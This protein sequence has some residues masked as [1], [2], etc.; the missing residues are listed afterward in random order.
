LVDA[1]FPD[2]I[3]RRKPAV[4]K[5]LNKNLARDISERKRSE[6]ALQKSREERFAEINLCEKQLSVLVN[7]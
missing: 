1:D 3:A 7:G 6:A 5:T 2:C 4:R